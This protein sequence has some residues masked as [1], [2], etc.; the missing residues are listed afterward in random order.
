MMVVKQ[1]S[2]PWEW[3]SGETAVTFD[4]WLT[5][6]AETRH[7]EHAEEAIRK[8]WLLTWLV[9]RGDVFAAEQVRPAKSRSQLLDRTK[10]EGAA[11]L[12]LP[13][14]THL[15][16]LLTIGSELY[17]SNVFRLTGL[18]V[19][20]TA[21]DIAR[22][23]DK[24]KLQEKLGTKGSRPSG[25]L[26]INPPPD[27]DTIRAAVHALTKDPELRILQ[28]FFW[29]WPLPIS[30]T[31]KSPQTDQALQ[32]LTQ[33]DFEKAIRQWE[34]MG[35]HSAE[36]PIARHNLAI[37]Y[38]V[39]A[40]DLELK[41]TR[42][43]LSEEQKKQRNAFWNRALDL[44]NIISDEEAVWS[45]LA[46]RIRT[47]EDAR[48]TTGYAR[49]LRAY[50]PVI[51]SS[52][53][54]SLAAQS[55]EA[56]LGQETD[57]HIARLVS[58]AHDSQTLNHMV[59]RIVETYRERLRACCK[60]AEEMRTSQ[61][62]QGIQTAEILITQSA[63]LLQVIDALTYSGSSLR[64]AA[65][66]YVA[67]N[68]FD[69]ATTYENKTHRYR[70][71]IPVFE[72][73]LT[74]ALGESTKKKIADE[75]AASKK[76]LE[77]GDIWFD[78]E[79][80]DQPQPILDKLEQARALA[81][82]T[83]YD[84]AISI[85]VDLLYGHREQTIL[86]DQ[87]HVV[88]K[89]LAWCLSRRSVKRVNDAMD[90]Q[91]IELEIIKN[92]RQRAVN[93][94]NGF[95]Y[96]F[97][98][99]RQGSNQGLPYLEC[100]ACGATI[101]QSYY[102]FSYKFNEEDVKVL[103]CPSCNTKSDEERDR[104][105][106]AFKR[107]V[108]ESAQDIQLAVELDDTNQQVK[109]NIADLKGIASSN[110]IT[111][112]SSQELRLK[113]GLLS[114]TD[115][116]KS[117]LSEDPSVRRQALE[118][119]GKRVAVGSRANPA[120]LSAILD[121]V[122]DPIRSVRDAAWSALNNLGEGWSQTDT[123]RRKVDILLEAASKGKP[124]I[125]ESAARAVKKIDPLK[126]E[127]LRSLQRSRRF[128][129]LA[130]TASVVIVSVGIFVGSTFQKSSEGDLLASIQL[131]TW[132]L[133]D[134]ATTFAR[135]EEAARSSD[136]TTRLHAIKAWKQFADKRTVVVPA[137]ILAQVDE[138]PKVV[139]A[140]SRAMEEIS[141]AYG[142]DQLPEVK[143]AIPG[144]LKAAATGPASA[145]KRAITLLMMIGPDD[146]DLIIP[147]LTSALRDIDKEVRVLA[148][149]ALRNIGPRANQAIPALLEALNSDDWDLRITAAEGLAA[150]GEDGL[151]AKLRIK[152]ML[153]QL[154]PKSPHRT[155]LSNV[156]ARMEVEAKTVAKVAKTSEAKLPKPQVKATKGG[157][158][159]K[160]LIGKEGS[161]EIP[162]RRD[163]KQDST[164]TIITLAERVES[165]QLL[166]AQMDHDTSE[167]LTQ[168]SKLGPSDQ[169]EQ[170]SGTSDDLWVAELLKRRV[171]E[172]MIYPYLA[173][174][175]GREGTVVLAV[176]I[177]SDGQL[178]KIEVLK[179]SGHSL[180]DDDAMETVKRATPLTMAQPM[181]RP[182]LAVEIP[183]VYRLRGN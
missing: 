152:S 120:L 175:Q 135:I 36:G 20:A 32:D 1:P 134:E 145:R 8:S 82:S 125:A 65:H 110:D 51:L 25:P 112:P 128:K 140:A 92:I 47:L 122:I 12:D 79:Y 104:R 22:H 159:D 137:L 144:L 118:L 49:R 183:V 150:V 44:W 26:P 138:N 68:V 102:H 45:W 131:H 13:L 158:V 90:Q 50:L 89:P 123:A 164:D 101:Q 96:S 86:R 42:Q 33:G 169:L 107:V 78:E 129:K 156:L 97:A 111:W 117:F 84:Q 141:T 9:D 178:S 133:L 28:E 75:L 53:N 15:E 172:A 106:I 171:A 18:P 166:S 180:L 55:A 3:R 31:D 88:Q 76:L 21:R 61:P 119:T 91:N 37:L 151:V 30:S 121:M 149:E 108:H 116:L 124:E 57:R 23:L 182:E 179:S 165:D 14:D 127:R 130:I 93:P 160:S 132:H 113:L 168:M 136:S 109:K 67:L 147:T 170:L 71:T 81:N 80:F 40:L 174:F 66:D 11:P 157:E 43:T 34:H 54:G 177:R 60:Q 87:E 77:S 2:R 99:A 94:T 38:H 4:Q 153:T 161:T 70:A 162:A 72:Q 163:H 63:P 181:G 85:L 73:A 35:P 5:Q 173:Q 59:M 167:P 142:Q 155:A 100:M 83:Q 146:H 176:V 105:R 58:Y 139:S 17:T 10:G 148:A 69:C 115:L 24:L 95:N 52:V 64:E 98:A 74:C 39:A 126:A 56:G 114:D 19:I 7:F 41:G 16:N 143:L 48:L 29:F 46:T 154:P 27:I 103:I 6:A 62:L